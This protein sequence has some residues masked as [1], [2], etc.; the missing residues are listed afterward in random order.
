MQTKSIHAS[1]Y[2]VVGDGTSDDTGALQ[3]A[4]NAAA[5]HGPVC[6]LPSGRFRIDGALT[7][8]PGCTL[9]GAS[10]GVPHSEH[11]IGSVLL[12]YGGRGDADGEPLVT[13]KPNAVVRNLT[14]HYPEQS[15]PDVAPYPWSIR[16]DGELCQ[17]T[18][19]TLTNPYQALDLGTCWNELH[20]VRNVFG[21]P[22]NIGVYVDRCTD[23]GRLENIHFNPNF[24]T[25]MALEPGFPR[26]TSIKAYLEENLVGFKIGKTDWEYITNSFVIFPKIGFHFDDFG[27]GPG[28]AV[29]TQS[30]S[31]ICPVAVR[32]DRVQPHAG[33]QFVNGQFMARI[34][35]AAQNTGPVKIANSG[36][37]GTPETKAH[38]DKAGPSTLV[39]NG[40]HFTGWDAAGAGEPCVIA[41][42]G[43][44]V[45]NGCDFMDVGKTAIRLEEGLVAASIVGNSFRGAPEA[46]VPDGAQV[47]MGFNTIL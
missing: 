5:K 7:V 10:G 39:L 20:T 17:I 2:G 36:F 23:I 22:L 3:S 11:P 47:E 31:D 34:E 8:P 29:V 9:R 40:C 19:M 37:W 25:R 1:D 13:L 21:C 24:W 38:I 12:A 43:R 18:D 33:V 26:A 6:Y 16:V 45:L 44:L 4:L 42:G 35:I 41:K 14:I 28:N 30:G 27:Y 32:V 15:L 46:G